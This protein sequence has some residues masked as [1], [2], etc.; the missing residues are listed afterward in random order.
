MK[1]RVVLFFTTH[2]PSHSH[3]VFQGRL[4]ELNRVYIV[5][6][7]TCLS[8]YLCVTTNLNRFLAFFV[9]YVANF[10][11]TETVKELF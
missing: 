6:H 9:S 10:S 3:N 1:L 11:E 8:K 7:K 2:S 4:F 5:V